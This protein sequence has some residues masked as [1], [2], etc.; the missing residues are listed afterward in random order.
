MFTGIVE[1]RGEVIALDLA[2]DGADAR[3]T[4]R[5][6]KVTQD[7]RHGDSI[8]V[9]GVCLTVVA[10]ADGTFTADVMSETL[11][12]TSAQAWVP[13]RPVN[14]ERSV[15]ADSRLGGH[16]VQGHVDGV[17]TVTG[18]DAHV[19]YDEVRIAVPLDLARFIAGKGAVAVDGVSLTV[20]AVTDTPTGAEFSL[21]II[22]ETRQATT[23]GLADVGTAVNV[24]V[25]VM[26]KYVERLLTFP[27]REA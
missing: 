10:A 2:A 4:I 11:H 17:G 22:P 3:V 9:S 6:P 19:G 5:G 13:G 26:A 1:E 15:R 8:A 27:H 12:R 14:L 7:V 23:L 18:R 24:E 20:I 16:V 21:G 25:D